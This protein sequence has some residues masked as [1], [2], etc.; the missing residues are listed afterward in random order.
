MK[1][2]NKVLLLLIIFLFPIP[3]PMVAGLKA[4]AAVTLISQIQ[5]TYLVQQAEDKLRLGNK[6]GATLDL[7]RSLELA[8]TNTAALAYLGLLR[9]EPTLRLISQRSDY[10]KKNLATLVERV[11]KLPL[12]MRQYTETDIQN[13]DKGRYLFIF[14]E[15]I[16]IYESDW[17][18][19]N[20]IKIDSQKA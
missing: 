11:S 2:K 3:I 1:H 19:A 12:P 16:K 5:A 18:K 15:G 8:P 20:L 17:D 14:S 6:W 4:L 7:W 9:P 10:P 13:D